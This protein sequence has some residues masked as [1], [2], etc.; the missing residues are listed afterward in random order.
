M[1]SIIEEAMLQGKGSIRLN[2]DLNLAKRFSAL[3]TKA[4]MRCFLELLS[5]L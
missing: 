4:M 5:V 3:Y 1:Q 2:V